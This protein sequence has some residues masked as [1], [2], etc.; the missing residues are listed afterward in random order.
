MTDNRTDRLGVDNIFSFIEMLLRGAGQ[1]MFQNN[2]WTGLLF[3]VGIFGGALL[4]GT[5]EVGWGA[6]V[7]LL[8]STCTGRLLRLPQEDGKQGLWGFN[9]VL[10]GCAFPTFL[11]NTVGMWLAL[12]LCAALTTWV[13]S[14]LDRVLS[15]WHIGSLTF[16][17]VLCTWLFLLAARTLNGIPTPHLP[18]PVLPPVD[19]VHVL[20]VHAAELPLYWLR[21]VSQVFLINSWFTGVCFLAGLLV[22]NWRAAV[23]AAAGSALALALALLFAA[24]TADVSAGLYGFSPV[25]TAIALGATFRTPGRRTLTWTLLGIAVTLFI[26]AGMDVLV[27][28]FGIATLTAPFCL[29]T[30][31]F[32]L[33]AAP[34]PDANPDAEATAK[35]D[36]KPNAV[37]TAKPDAGPNAGPNAKSG[38]KQGAKS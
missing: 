37:P 15:T 19:G 24:P 3:L 13:R 11:G 38:A 9:G 10:V 4:E 33:P 5:P 21:G 28:P 26:Q 7:G 31:L 23:W 1:V 8:A 17:F 32:L 25:L 14:G 29:A 36:V 34:E 18:H 16:P 22:S 20:A 12:I 2:N 6:L 27:V 35:P 30:W